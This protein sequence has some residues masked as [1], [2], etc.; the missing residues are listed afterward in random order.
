MNI[1]SLNISIGIMISITL[2]LRKLF[3]NIMPNRVFCILWIVIA[4]RMLTFIKI[5]SKFSFW[6]LFIK[7]EA[8]VADYTGIVYTPEYTP[9]S[10]IVQN[11]YTLDS[12]IYILLWSIIASILGIYFIFQYIELLVISKKSSI[13]EDFKIS[14]IIDK[15]LVKRFIQI[16]VTDYLTSPATLGII[17]PTIYFPSS[18]DFRNKILLKFILLHEIGHIK[19]FHA[20]I[21]IFFTILTCLYW[22]N[23]LVW[24]MYFS[25]DRD[26][27]ISA[28]RFVIK[29]VGAEN[30]ALY[31]RILISAAENYNKRK[32]FLFHFKN[33]LLKERVEA[34]MKYKKLTL[35]ALIVTFI[36]PSFAFTV[37]ATT[38]TVITGTE[39]DQM[40]PA[41]TAVEYGDPV[42]NADDIYLEV[43]WNELEPY[44]YSYG[45]TKAVD[46]YYIQGY[47]YV[48]YGYIPPKSITIVTHESGN[49]YEGTLSL[50]SYVYDASNDKY[51]GYY[52]GTVYLQ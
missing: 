5:N 22:Y 48:T 32:S 46:S 33:N 41:I 1:L 12:P 47:K 23:P 34:I 27:E 21:K 2:L 30:R 42:D 50:T 52:S 39:L 11:S 17:R 9:L 26:M 40:E 6:N 4:A 45:T 31:A 38:D 37:F 43:S 36:V 28:D 7:L 20:L 29:E 25:I 14:Y 49:R 19:H 18:F 10:D 8:K 16:K 24:M 15:S 13:I 3:K 44:I 51:T 35:G